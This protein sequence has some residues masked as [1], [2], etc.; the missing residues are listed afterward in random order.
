MGGTRVVRWEAGWSQSEFLAAVMKAR[1]LAPGAVV[2]LA[3]RHKDGCP[4]PD[5]GPCRCD[6]EVSASIQAAEE[7]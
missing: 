1:G 5:G 2:N 6:P 4:K 7:A 3:Y